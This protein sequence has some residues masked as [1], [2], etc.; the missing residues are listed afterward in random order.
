MLAGEQVGGQASRMVTHT[1]GTS[2]VVPVGSRGR[3]VL[4]NRFDFVFEEFEEVACREGGA[5]FLRLF[6]CQSFYSVK[7]KL[8]VV[9]V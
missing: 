6:F 9:F 2:N 7:E 3:L 4:A 5:H 1:Q 8:R